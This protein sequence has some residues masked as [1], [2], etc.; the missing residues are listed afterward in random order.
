MSKVNICVEIGEE[1]LRAYETEARTEGITVQS[2]LERMVNGLLRD[3]EREE[4]EGTDHP[5]IAS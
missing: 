1:A 3:M 4:E 2:L 5:I